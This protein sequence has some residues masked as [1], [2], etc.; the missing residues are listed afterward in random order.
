MKALRF[1][2][3]AP[4][5]KALYEHSFCWG[6]ILGVSLIAGTIMTGNTFGQRCAKQHPNNSEAQHSCVERLARG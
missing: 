4:T 3:S 6:V 5:G 2:F 1:L